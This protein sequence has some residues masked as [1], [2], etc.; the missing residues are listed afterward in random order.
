M[1]ISHACRK[2]FIRKAYFPPAIDVN[3]TKIQKGIERQQA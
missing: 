1:E 2:W 3:I